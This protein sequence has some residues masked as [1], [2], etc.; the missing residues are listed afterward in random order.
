MSNPVWTLEDANMFCGVG[1]TDNTAANHLVLTEVKLPG[2][3]MQY[4]DHRAGGAPVAIEVSTVIAR[5]ECTFVCVGMTPQIMGLI[6]SWTSSHE[7]VLDLWRDPRSRHRRGGAGRGGNSG[8]A[9]PCGPAE[10]SARRS[11]AHQLRDPWHPAL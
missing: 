4:V 7:L 5:L 3:D 9:W 1:P 6:G 10:L 2:L 8:P 11:D